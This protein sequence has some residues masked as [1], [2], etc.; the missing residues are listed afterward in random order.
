M[1]IESQ[2]LATRGDLGYVVT[3]IAAHASDEVGRLLR[4]LPETVRVRQLG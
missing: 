4:E 2:Q 1:N 3:D